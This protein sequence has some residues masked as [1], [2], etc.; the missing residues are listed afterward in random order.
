MII[1]GPPLLGGPRNAIIAGSFAFRSYFVAVAAKFGPPEGTNF[2]IGGL[3][4]SLVQIINGGLGAEWCSWTTGA[5]GLVVQFQQGLRDKSCS[6]TTSAAG[7]ALVLP[8]LATT[9]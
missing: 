2:I 9:R 1:K 7:A 6:W 4:G 5:A 8:T 3:G